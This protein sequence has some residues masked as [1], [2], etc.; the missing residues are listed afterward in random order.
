M[1]EF[2][3]YLTVAVLIFAIGSYFVEKEN[4]AFKYED[5]DDKEDRWYGLFAGS[6]F[7]PL[8]IVLGTLWLVWFILSAPG[9][10]LANR[11]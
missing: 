2:Y 8:L 5:Q 6:L 1:L 9:R 7:W 4:N 3:L 10:Y 11:K